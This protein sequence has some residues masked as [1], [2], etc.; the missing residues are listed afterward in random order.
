MERADRV[1]W[2][3]IDGG[4]HLAVAGE[5]AILSPPDRT[6]TPRTVRLD[7]LDAEILGGREKADSDGD[8]GSVGPGVLH[9]D[10]LATGKTGRHAPGVEKEH[11]YGIGSGVDREFLVEDGH[12]L[13]RRT[14]RGEHAL[15]RDRQL[16]HAN[17]QG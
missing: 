8:V 10:A 7:D 15:G 1:R 6:K 5:L 11:P 13:R 17:A 12:E 14:P 9:L 16:G 3:E 2:F 4:V